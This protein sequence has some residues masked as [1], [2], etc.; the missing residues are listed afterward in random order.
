MN[1]VRTSLTLTT[2]AGADVPTSRA[3]TCQPNVSIT[4]HAI[5]RAMPTGN[6]RSRCS[7]RSLTLPST[8]VPIAPLACALVDIRPPYT[9]LTI[10]GGAEMNTTLPAG[11][12][13]ICQHQCQHDVRAELGRQDIHNAPQASEHSHDS[14]EH[15]SPCTQGRRSSYVRIGALVTTSSAR[16]GSRRGAL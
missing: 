4:N 14:S 10:L 12:E 6:S 2:S 11:I 5:R 13:S 9:A 3:N 15:T 1:D 16:R 8:I 7:C